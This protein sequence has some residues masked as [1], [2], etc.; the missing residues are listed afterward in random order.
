MLL[1][2]VQDTDSLIP[3]DQLCSRCPDAVRGANAASPDQLCPSPRPWPRPW[4]AEEDTAT[5]SAVP[6]VLV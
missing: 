1:P 3:S 4:L 6:T 2:S 5:E